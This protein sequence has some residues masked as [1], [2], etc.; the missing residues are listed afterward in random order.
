MASLLVFVF[1][2][3]NLK[4]QIC[5]WACATERTTRTQHSG[6]TW[7]ICAN[8]NG[9]LT[10]IGAP[11]TWSLEI[12]S[13][14]PRPERCETYKKAPQSSRAERAGQLSGFVQRTAGCVLAGEQE[15]QYCLVHK[16]FSCS[17]AAKE[18]Y[19][20][21]TLFWAPSFCCSSH[22]LTTETHPAVD[23]LSCFV[24]FPSRRRTGR[25][26]RSRRT[27]ATSSGYADNPPALPSFSKEQESIPIQLRNR[28]PAHVHTTTTHCGHCHE[29]A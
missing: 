9:L 10:V 14:M 18:V 25:W 15:F 8:G 5:R 20:I 6:S 19:A 12:P 22:S 3:K 21:P 1:F 4:N 17:S 24:L 23:A 28:K 16:S 13:K 11:F 29:D 2:Q 26:R 7:L 27:S